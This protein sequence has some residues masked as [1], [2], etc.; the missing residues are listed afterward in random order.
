MRY[1]S[2][3]DVNTWASILS[4]DA[5]TT[6]YTVRSL[7]N[8]TEYTFE[9]RA[10]DS[11]RA[12]GDQAGPAS[13]ATATPSTA[14]RAPSQMSNVQHTVTGVT[15]GS[16]GTVT[17]TWDDPEDD[18]VDQYHARVSTTSNFDGFSDWVTIV[19]SASE[20]TY[21]FGPA[22]IS[23]SSTVVFYELRAVNIVEGDDDLPGPATAITVSRTNTPVPTTAPPAA[24]TGFSV[25]AEWDDTNS[26]WDIV[27]R[28]TDPSD[29]DIDKYQYRQSTDGG[30]NWNPD[31]TD[32]TGSGATTT[33]RRFNR[34]TA[35][36]TYTFQIRAVDTDL[37]GD[38]GNGASS[39]AVATTP[40]APNAPTV[41]SVTN[42]ADDSDTEEKED[43]T[44]LTLTWT[45]GADVPGVFITDYEY[46]QRRSGAVSWSGW[47]DADASKIE[48]VLSYT[49]T[50][51][52]PSTTYEF[53][54]R[55][56][57]GSLVSDPSNTARG[58]TANP[59]ADDPLT[60]P[61]APTGLSAAA[62]NEQ[63]TLTWTNPNNRNILGYRYRVAKEG[64][65][66]DTVDWQ[67]I[68]GSDKD[69]TSHTLTDL[70][71][72]TTYSFQV[73]AVGA[74]SMIGAASETVTATPRVPPPPQPPATPA[75][76]EPPPTEP[77]TEPPPSAAAADR[78]AADR[79]ATNRA[80]ARANGDGVE[81]RR[82]GYD[83][84]A[85]DRTA[86][87]RTA[88]NRAAARANGDGVESRRNGYDYGG[89][90]F[91]SVDHAIGGC[92]KL[93]YRIPAG[94]FDPLFGN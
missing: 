94:F 1:K 23:T 35:S 63:V 73:Q 46:R 82:N 18:S 61:E 17:F 70:T 69:T 15:D 39:G 51:L 33:V 86:A 31:W 52:L 93:W 6:D 40:G 28:W 13:S 14:A 48:S 9:V 91:P 58:T 30:S 20:G 37:A 67:P 44:Q 54:V 87:D 41:L 76:T 5:S 72:G 64:T 45:A 65:A 19:S 88:T 36:T 43:Q 11:D 8:G 29:S 38:S 21:T 62:G 78:T 75:P 12:E 24:P 32:S 85:A 56:V 3:G 2:D 59:P 60:A 50:G 42:V 84:A 7:T 57:A 22:D 89:E 10:V 80:A 79:T 68:N 74:G 55:A 53:Q 25:A 66:I 49:V 34:V 92:G 71:N 47:E 81:S 77:P 26:H 4:S 90:T 83:R 16:G 27:L